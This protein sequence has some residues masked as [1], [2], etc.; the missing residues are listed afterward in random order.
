MR[1]MVLIL[2]VLGAPV[3]T[4]MAQDD[5]LSCSITTSGAPCFIQQVCA[6][7]TLADQAPIALL[8]FPI[9]LPLP[10]SGS[11]GVVIPTFHPPTTSS[12][13]L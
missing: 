4:G 6:A 8:V 5:C 9:L 10:T 3:L 7:V 13:L 1:I 12:S 11:P 2:A